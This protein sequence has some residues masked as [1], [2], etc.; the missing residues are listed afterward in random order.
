MPKLSVYDIARLRRIVRAQHQVITRT[1][2]LE[3]GMPHS[4]VDSWVMPGRKWAK[5]LPGVY[6]T[7]TGKV[8]VEQ[9]QVA[10]LL[11]AGP[12]SVITGPAAIRLHRLRSPGSDMID[13][14][15]PWAVKRQSTDFVRIHRTR[16]VPGFYRRGPIRFARAARAVADAARQFTTLDDV[17]AVVAEAVQKQACS[18]AEIGLE[19]E[20]GSSR[21][22]THL[23]AALAEVRDGI[24]SVA[25][26]RFRHRIQRSDLP[27]PRYNVFLR[28]ADGTD[29]G[30]ADAWWADAGVSA[31]IDSQEYHFFRDG[32]LRTDAKH[33]RML[34][35]GILPHHF[36]PS[37][38]DND[39]AAIYDELKS[40]IHEGRQ[41]PRLRIVAFDALG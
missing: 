4:T 17:R 9:R 25:E 20:E 12:D 13:V 40:S 27:P 2:A 7:V 22:S 18:I 3:C 30:E 19:L 15:I 1:Q 36:A 32:W 14:L 31:E 29:I 34:K 16:R 23:R 37:R 26:A 5:I 38:V 6:S 8:T 21:D 11:Y 41:R 24:R 33:S 39:W 10:A 35:Y 28:A